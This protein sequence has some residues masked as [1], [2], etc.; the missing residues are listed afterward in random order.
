[1]NIKKYEIQIA[2]IGAVISECDSLEEAELEVREME[3]E[4]ARNEEYEPNYYEIKEV[5]YSGNLI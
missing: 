1:M 3:E 4:D 5:E 2:S